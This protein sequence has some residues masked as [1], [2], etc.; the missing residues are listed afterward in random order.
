MLANPNMKRLPI[1]ALFSVTLFV[2]CSQSERIDS[3]SPS[4]AGSGEVRDASETRGD[5]EKIPD[6]LLKIPT[7]RACIARSVSS[8]GS[9][10]IAS[11]SGTL[12]C[13]VFRGSELEKECRDMAEMGKA[14]RNLD[15]SKCST[16]NDWKKSNCEFGVAVRLAVKNEDPKACADLRSSAAS[17]NAEP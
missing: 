16:L 2:S 8:C 11:D 13:G 1:I 6:A 3:P 14:F 10:L 9:D 5:L 7:Y 12:D 15:S 4:H 17:K